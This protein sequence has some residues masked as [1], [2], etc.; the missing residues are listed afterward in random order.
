VRPPRKSSS[1]RPSRYAS[2]TT[3]AR[4]ARG[5]GR[6]RRSRG[7]S[8]AHREVEQPVELLPA[9]RCLTALAVDV[10]PP[11]RRVDACGLQIGGRVRRDPDVLPCGRNHQQADA[12]EALLVGD[13]APTRVDVREP[14]PAQPAPST[15]ACHRPAEY[16]SDRDGETPAWPGARRLAC[17]GRKPRKGDPALS[18]EEGQPAPRSRSGATEARTCRSPSSAGSLS[19]STSIPRTTR[20]QPKRSSR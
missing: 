17:E 3:R 13:R 6:A 15:A 4:T 5:G 20:V 18:V 10:L 12:L 19:S 7:A 11:P 8:A 9:A 1:V 14:P 2:T 16:P